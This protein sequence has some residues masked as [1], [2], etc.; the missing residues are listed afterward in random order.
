MGS[1]TLD[2]PTSNLPDPLSHSFDMD[3]AK[4]IAELIRRI[5]KVAM[6][7]RHSDELVFSITK[8]AAT[9]LV[10]VELASQKFLERTHLQE[11][12]LQQP[13]I[14]GEEV[15]IITFEFDQWN[16]TGG[17]APKDR[18]DVLGL[19]SDGRL[20]VAELKRG[21]VPDAVD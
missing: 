2:E 20:V 8:T 1:E 19:D 14:I 21:R 9:P 16:A 18:L 4:I 5:M 13:E 12:V 3:S 6:S 15:L 11:W 10:G 17:P 7:A